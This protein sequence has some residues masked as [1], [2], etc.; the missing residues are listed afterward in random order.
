MLHNLILCL[1]GGGFDMNYCEPLFKA[2]RTNMAPTHLNINDDKHSDIRSEDAVA[3]ELG[4]V[5]E[6]K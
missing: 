4:T 6:S 1:K 5:D 3:M 2:R